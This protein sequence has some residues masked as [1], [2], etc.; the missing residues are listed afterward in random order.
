MRSPGT[1]ACIVVTSFS[2]NQPGY[3]DFSYRLHALSGRFNLVVMSQE[4]ITQPELIVPGAKYISL[5][6]RHGKLGWLWY[7]L[8]CIYFIRR[9]KPDLLVLLHSGVSPV[10]LL[11]GNIPTSLYWNEHPTNLMHLPGKGYPVRHALT[12]ALHGL[13][14]LGARHASIVMPIGEE[15]RD[16][17]LTHGCAREQIEMIYMGVQ[18]T[19]HA[20]AAD[21]PDCRDNPL[22]LVYI[23]TVSVPRGRDVMLEGMAILASRHANVRLTIVGA[24]ASQLVYCNDRINQLGIKSHVQVIGRVQGSEVPA[25]LSRA[26][27]GVCLWEDTP[28]YRFNPPTKL[29]EYLAAGLPVLASDIRTH[30]R[31]VK[32]GENGL[33][34]EYSPEGFASAVER[35]QS[36]MAA[37]P[38][39]KR[40]ALQSGEQYLWSRIEPFFMKA[41][42]RVL[43]E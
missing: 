41:M 31:Y 20:C 17:L 18:D 8:K 24:D 26:D 39:M 32:S 22:E 6:R 29:F 21:K 16:D 23:G 42:E 37:L 14:F 27:F 35:L 1:P 3:L 7:L 12:A 25:F 4:Q 34:F 30:T 9:Y 28:W 10:T 43:P 19:F 33:I 13:F 40:K 36:D 5:G 15:H 11:T 38:E 2:E